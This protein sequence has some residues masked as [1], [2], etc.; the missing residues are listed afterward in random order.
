MKLNSQ[1]LYNLNE[2]K[3][4]SNKDFEKA[5]NYLDKKYGSYKIDNADGSITSIEESIQGIVD[6][7]YDYTD[8]NKINRQEY[9]IIDFINE[10]NGQY[11]CFEI[12]KN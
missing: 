4:E 12:I 11:A 9:S 6:S 7:Y 10:F 1:I 2:N 8:Y 3:E 5:K